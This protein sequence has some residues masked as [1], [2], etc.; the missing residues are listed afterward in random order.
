[1]GFLIQAWEMSQQKFTMNMKQVVTN[2]GDGTLEN[3]TSVNE[4][5]QFFSLI[6]LHTMGRL[7]EE[8]YSKDRRFKFDARGDAR[9][10]Y[11]FQDLV[12]E[13]GR[14]LG[15]SVENGLYRGKKNEIGFDGLWKAAD[16][17]YIIMESKT[18]DDYSI[19]IESVIGYRDKL[20]IDHKIP[21]KKCS[22]LIVYG[23]DDKMALR[24]TVKGSNEN[25]NIRLISANA[26]FQLVKI[27]FE[28]KNEVVLNQINNMLRPRDYFVLDNLVELVFPQTDSAIDV[29]EEADEET[30]NV[31]KNENASDSAMEPDNSEKSKQKTRGRNGYFEIVGDDIPDGVTLLF[32]A[33]HQ[34]KASGYPVPGTDDFVVVK[35]SDMRPVET[36]SCRQGLKD[37]RKRLIEAGAVQNNVFVKSVR[38]SSP[39]TAVACCYGGSLNGK[40]MWV[41]EEGITL[42]ELG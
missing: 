30:D 19:S 17:S 36:A 15:Y 29:V 33:G 23:R 11:A 10:G 18:S 20:I 14:R 4:L 34:F 32:Y 27:C 31:N 9:R 6:D 42:K 12:N 25:Q 26:L 38:F 16:G 39:S 1:M 41:T 13:M 37:Q 3:E 21:K 28:V 2:A 35:G 7:L 22:I 24:N 40:T 8:C 5:R